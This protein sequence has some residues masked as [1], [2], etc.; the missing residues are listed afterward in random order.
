MS[1][2]EDLD[3]G[4]EHYEVGVPVF[5]EFY[6]G[7]AEVI[8]TKDAQSLSDHARRLAEEGYPTAR[9]REMVWDSATVWQ[10]GQTWLTVWGNKVQVL[11]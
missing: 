9:F 4:V 3:R 2:Y 1:N 5:D 6:D 8:Q 10:F 11:N 7:T